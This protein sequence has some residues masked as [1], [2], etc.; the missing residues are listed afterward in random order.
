MNA[1][2]K[3]ATKA[4]AK[5]V[6]AKKPAARKPAAP[7]S[8]P[9]APAAAPAPQLTFA[10]QLLQAAIKRGSSG[11]EIDRLIAMVERTDVL[12]REKAHTAAKVALM[13]ENIELVK[14]RRND[15][16]GNA[17]ISLGKLTATMAPLLAKHGL[18]A[19]WEPD[20]SKGAEITVTCILSHTGGHS[21][22]ASITVPRDA[23]DRK[24]DL[25]AIKSS[26]TYAR[27]MTYEA[28]C[29]LAATEASVD[30]D[31]NGAGQQDEGPVSE[32]LKQARAEADQGHA[33][34]QKFWKYATP[35]QRRELAPQL[36]ALEE[37]ATS[38]GAKGRR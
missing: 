37:R 10:Q 33:A 29:G 20:Q 38:A 12:E 21:T 9:A 34:F 5:P 31:G 28:V 17:Y 24:N 15:D 16:F 3:S 18:T 23:D 19:S 8:K 11:E 22:R 6:A 30:N 25:Q 27:S 4:A 35:E 7:R 2:T 1:R 36:K 14:D 26:M 13:A 32:L